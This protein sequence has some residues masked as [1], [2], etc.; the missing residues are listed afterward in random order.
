MSFVP[1]SVA[2]PASPTANRQRLALATLALT[3]LMSS[4]G[5]SIANV[6]LPTFAR[7]FGASFQS[8]QWIVL[9]YLL[10]VTALVVSVGRLGDLFGRRRLMLG[11]VAVFTAA[12]LACAAA[13]A[14]WM[15]VAARAVQGLGAAVMM[16][17]TMALVGE[18]VPQQRA[19]RAMGLLGTMS[20]IGT[21]MGPSLGG[22]LIAASG[23]PALFWI[24]LPLGSAA[25]FMAHRYL[26]ADR[27]ANKQ[28]SFDYGGSLLLAAALASYA[29][30]MTV[31]RGAFG[32]I[33]AL[34]LGSAFAGFGLFV[35]VESRV[36]APLVQPA[37]FRI[38]LVSQGFVASALATTV[39]MT[40]LV[41][42]P[43]H[44]AGALHLAP[45][46]IGLVMSAGPLVAAVMG[47][48]AGKAVDRF[49]AARVAA[50]GLMLMVAGALALACTSA[51]SGI[52][53]YVVPLVT[54]TAGFS[55]FQ[56]ANNTAVVVGIDPAQRGVVSGLLTLS[57]N[58]GLVT[59]ASVMG[60]VFSWAA[61]TPDIATAGAQ[62]V[63]AGTHAA[64]AVAAALAGIALLA[65][66][67]P[68]QARRRGIAR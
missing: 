28:V 34:L 9:A 49:G 26:P 7:A 33:N 50:T 19:G 27:A 22:W 31:G 55:I 68:M 37:L 30:A 47:V 14:L 62:A 39:A 12:S 48:P 46:Q 44:L 67:L 43:F 10:A 17:L 40:T 58:L 64:F 66:L 6:G 24:N 16:A 11:G 42:G 4:L 35:L 3:M 20:A 60:A 8:V 13:D 52:A 29:L 23:W 38:R 54:L 2:L 36:R 5:T 63:V 21:A 18:A 61:G 32:P 53:G 15:L 41:V 25:L 59:G 65:I 51:E 57:R 1:S 45:A 56:A